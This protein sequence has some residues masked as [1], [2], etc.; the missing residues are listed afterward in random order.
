MLI[1]LL[2]IY[3]NLRLL[4]IEWR[5]AWAIVMQA[6]NTHSYRLK[7]HQDIKVAA[8]AKFNQAN[9]FPVLH[10]RA[11][12][13]Q[14]VNYYR[15]LAALW[16]EFYSVSSKRWKI[17]TA[18]NIKAGVIYG[19]FLDA[20]F[21]CYAAGALQIHSRSE[22]ERNFAIKTTLSVSAKTFFMPPPANGITRFT[23]TIGKLLESV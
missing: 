11:I 9:L 18:G 10:I 17:Y 22:P 13:A 23:L 14:E 20:Y 16:L 4:S 7:S 1:T 5:P 21:W 8:H 3:L 2:R 15:A 19:R 12:N 6:T